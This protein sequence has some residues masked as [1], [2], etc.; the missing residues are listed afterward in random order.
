MTHYVFFHELIKH[1]VIFYN[2]RKERSVVGLTSDDFLTGDLFKCV[3][4]YCQ[5]YQIVPFAYDSR[6]PS[7]HGT[8]RSSIVFGSHTQYILWMTLISLQ[9]KSM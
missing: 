4:S 1:A 9:V 5:I 2:Q 6:N 7:K 3:L 8:R